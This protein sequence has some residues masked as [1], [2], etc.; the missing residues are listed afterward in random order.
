M[1]QYLAR[2]ASTPA[3]RPFYDLAFVR[4]APSVYPDTF[5]QSIFCLVTGSALRNLHQKHRS[6]DVPFSRITAR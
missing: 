6:V 1:A 4:S 5:S 3:Q 2:I